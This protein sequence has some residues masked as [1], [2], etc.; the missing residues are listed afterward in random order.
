MIPLKRARVIRRL[1]LGV[2]LKVLPPSWNQ[3]WKIASIEKTAKLYS[4]KSMC[5]SLTCKSRNSAPIP[6]TS[7]RKTTWQ[8]QQLSTKLSKKATNKQTTKT[9][10]KLNLTRPL[11]ISDSS[12]SISSPKKRRWINKLAKEICN[13]QS[14]TRSR[15]EI[16]SCS[17]VIY[18]KLSSIAISRSITCLTQKIKLWAIDLCLKLHQR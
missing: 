2:R 6:S 4:N 11:I 8:S 1:N 18:P 16:H 7:L 12:L 5:G 15:A 10:R 3:L 13:R 14:S 17:K 9:R